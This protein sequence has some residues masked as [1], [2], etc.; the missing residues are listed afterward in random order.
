MAWAVSTV[1]S[2]Q[3]YT[4]QEALAAKAINGVA[5]SSTTCWPGRRPDRH[6]YGRPGR[7]PHLKGATI[8]TINEDPIQ[9]FL[10]TLDDPNIAFILLVIGVLCVAVE[11][12]HPRC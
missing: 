6:D 9:S 10:H 7:R 3:S 4:A 1:Q 8:V 11:F 2:A 5:T 12:F